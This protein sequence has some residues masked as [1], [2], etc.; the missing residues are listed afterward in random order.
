MIET[1]QPTPEERGQISDDQVASSLS[2]FL[3]PGL[4]NPVGPRVAFLA[5]FMGMN[6]RAARR[7][8]LDAPSAVRA[9][10][11]AW[12]RG[13]QAAL[14]PVCLVPMSDLVPEVDTDSGEGQ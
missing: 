14:Q 2:R 9:V 12:R 7:M 10:E 3:P 1:N 5:H 11:A 4:T 6:G 8:Y 13:S